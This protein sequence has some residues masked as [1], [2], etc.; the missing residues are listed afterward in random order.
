MLLQLIL[1]SVIWEGLLVQ[2][3]P[4]STAETV[5]SENKME[6]LI[7]TLKRH[8]GVKPTHTEILWESYTLVVG[9]I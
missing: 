7:E 1:L 2:P 9:E 5:V 6:K 3:P 8:E 4:A